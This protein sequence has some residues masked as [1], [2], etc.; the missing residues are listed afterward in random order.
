[1]DIGSLLPRH[2]RFR[3]DHTCFVFGGRRFSYREFNAEVN[4]LAN[5]M[6]GAGLEKG[7]KIATV[8]PNCLELMVAY[9]AAARIGVVIVP[10]SPL[11]QASGL[12]TLLADSDTV[13]VLADARFAETLGAIRAD[14]PAIADDRYVLVGGAA[15]GFR[16]Y[17]DFVA[18]AS[19]DN[20]AVAGN[21]GSDDYNIMYTS[22]TTGAPKGI[23]HTHQIRAMYCTLFAEAWRMTPES[24]VLHA[25]AIVFN[26]AMLDLMPWMYLGA[27]YIL[28]EA[29]DP[30]RVIAEIEKER[31]THVIMVPS[32]IMALLNHPD[33]DP[34]KLASLEMIQSVGAPLLLEYKNRLNEALPNRFYELYGLTEGFVTILDRDDAMRKAGSVGCP[35]PFFEMRIL[36]ADGRDCPPG[37]VGEICGRGP[38]LMKEYYKRPDLTAAAVVD[39]W[40]RSGDLGMVDEEGYLYLVDRKKDMIISGGVNV[41]PKDIEEIAVQHPDVRDAAVFGAPDDKWGETPVA[42][43][44]PIDGASA[45]PAAIRDWVNE[46]VGAKFQRLAEVVVLDA[47]PTNVAGKTLKREIAERYIAG[48]KKPA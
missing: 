37:T 41:Y 33:F 14:L 26:G 44:V 5:A 9:W 30:A 45:D 19:P 1:M 27:T 38:I 7:E 11:L 20:P 2:A 35:P 43:I 34:A 22:G 17:G 23:V 12:K 28:H 24:I 21:S 8:L 4:R 25:G 10:S 31:V 13:L 16:T 32:Q 47:F 6:L 15:A 42:A 3:P 18:G 29:F 48:R 39:G 46:R 40:L 36:D